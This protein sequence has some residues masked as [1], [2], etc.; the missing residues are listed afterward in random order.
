M[1]P[2]PVPSEAMLRHFHGIMIRTYVGSS[3][4]CCGFFFENKI[5]F[6]EEYRTLHT[7]ARSASSFLTRMIG[8]TSGRTS[9]S[10]LSNVEG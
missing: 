6:C 9:I 7:H 8:T 4:A 1:A 5:N 10:Q 3:A 2:A